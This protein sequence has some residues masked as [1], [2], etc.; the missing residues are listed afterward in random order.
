MRI[1]GNLDGVQADLHVHEAIGVIIAGLGRQ[2]LGSDA[3]ATTCDDPS[4]LAHVQGG[5]AISV[6]DL[7]LVGVARDVEVDTVRL[8]PL[9]PIHVAGAGAADV[10]LGRIM[11]HDDLPVSIR[12]GND[13]DEPLVIGRPQVAEPL[14]ATILAGRAC[15]STTGRALA[16]I[17][18][19]IGCLALGTR[20]CGF[21]T[22]VMFWVDTLLGIKDIAIH[23][24]IVHLEVLVLHRGAVVL[25]RHDPLA[26]AGPCV[27]DLLVPSLQEA[28]ATVIMVSQNA[29]PGD[30]DEGGR[31]HRL[32]HVCKLVAAGRHVLIPA[33]GVNTTRVKVVADVDDVPRLLSFFLE[34]VVDVD[35]LVAHQALDPA[36]DAADERTLAT[37]TIGHWTG[38]AGIGIPLVLPIAHGR[39]LVS[40]TSVALAP[41]AKTTPIAD[42]EEVRYRLVYAH[43]WP[44]S[45]VVLCR[46][47]GGVGN[48]VSRC[49]LRAIV[50]APGVIV[51]CV[52]V[53]GVRVAASQAGVLAC[54]LVALSAMT[55]RQFG[56]ASGRAWS[57]SWSGSRSGTGGRTGGRTGRGR[58]F[59]A[60]AAA[61]QAAGHNSQ[62]GPCSKMTC[63]HHG[64]CSGGVRLRNSTTL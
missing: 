35:H 61:G 21:R 25:T 27:V 5:P 8:K 39:W 20:I 60:A 4:S 41:I 30:V 15:H 28:D 44:H 3:T 53:Q 48:L 54:V 9:G 22:D 49:V 1:C 40:G 10:V 55:P 33:M 6:V 26:A 7:L 58:R 32:P 11:I 18:G 51:F 12:L 59:A 31:V 37:T 43:A 45:T 38:L 2:H 64:R 47:I 42:G 13:V 56:R 16:G 14:V 19:P 34:V 23:E 17:R 63:C 62:G 46:R 57:R 24:E 52:L 29:E 36:L 50:R